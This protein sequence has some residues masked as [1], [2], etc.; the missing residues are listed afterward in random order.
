MARRKLE[1]LTLVVAVSRPV[2]INLITAGLVREV[3]EGRH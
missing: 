1:R 2:A 3:Q